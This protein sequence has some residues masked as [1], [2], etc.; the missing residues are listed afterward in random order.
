ML[1]G[2]ASVLL[3]AVSLAVSGSVTAAAVAYAT[4]SAIALFAWDLP[5]AGR[6]AHIGAGLLRVRWP[7]LRGLLAPALP[8]G[9]SSAI[10]SV[11]SNLPR[12]VVAASL[13]SAPLAVL[14]ALSQ[15]PMI[16]HLVVNAASQ[17]ALPLFARDAGRPGSSYRA[18]LTGLVV[19]GA[20]FG[21][22]LLFAMAIGGAW[23]LRLL[24]GAAYAEH[25][26]VLLWLTAAAAVTFVS[27]FLG[28]AVAASGRFATQAAISATSLSV[29]AVSI[30]PLTSRYGLNGAA[31]ALVAGALV[32]LGA[33]VLVTLRSLRDREPSPVVR[34]PAVLADGVQ[35]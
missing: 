5:R 25:T 29:V 23:L 14:A 27:V 21:A 9:L 2:A 13:G 16:G 22:G 33:Y 6:I 26:G 19:A 30:W 18:R 1:N 10:G 24:Y 31:G 34:M 35:P 32:E 15:I 17:A 11:Q 12:Y 8:L 20:A 3:V 28:T 4:G 7:V